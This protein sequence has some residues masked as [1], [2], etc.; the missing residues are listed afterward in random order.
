MKRTA[1]TLVCIAALASA[2]GTSDSKGDSQPKSS[3]EPA[4]TVS[5][6][7]I[8]EVGKD[9]KP[10]VYTAKEKCL[11]YS[12]STKD[13]SV[14]DDNAD[15]DAYIAGAAQVG[16]LQRIEVHKG[17]FFTSK[18]CSTWTL[19]DDSTSA[20]ADPA[21]VAGACEILV[22]KDHTL[23][24]AMAFPKQKES[25]ADKALRGDVQERLFSIV[26]ANNE[27]LA[28]PAGQLVD[29]LDDPEEYIED[30]KPVT[31]ITDAVAKIRSTCK[32]D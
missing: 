4:A 10:A 8:Y 14:M 1:L 17:E 32:P 18:S 26:A 5:A 27:E 29:F 7:G 3:A 21:T 20:S 6:D 9:I 16:S 23:D 24:D 30:G 31:L 11:A 12:A 19:E 22:G 2:C 15:D 28:D 13:F 25:A